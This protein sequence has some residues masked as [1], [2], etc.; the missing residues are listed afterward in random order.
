MVDLKWL[1][2]ATSKQLKAIIASTCVPIHNVND[3]TKESTSTNT[4]GPEEA[5]LALFKTQTFA[6]QFQLIETYETD[7][8]FCFALLAKIPTVV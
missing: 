3:G 7:I 6:S 8:T 1:L 2:R 4:H 5:L